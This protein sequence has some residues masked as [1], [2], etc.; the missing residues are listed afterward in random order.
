MAFARLSRRD[1]QSDDGE[2]QQRGEEHQVREHPGRP[3]VAGLH[4][5]GENAEPD[6]HDPGCDRQAEEEPSEPRRPTGANRHGHGTPRPAPRGPSPGAC[7]STRASQA[8]A[9]TRARGGDDLAA[10]GLGL[11]PLR[12]V[13][14]VADHRVLEPSAA[15]DRARHHDARCSARCRRRATP[16][17]STPHPAAFSSASP[18]LHRDRAAH[19][20]RRR[21]PRSAPARR[22]P[23]SPRRPGTCR[24]SRRARRSPRPS[25]R[26]ADRPPRRYRAR[27]AVPT[28]VEKPRMSLNSTVTSTSRCSASLAS[29][30]SPADHL[31][32]ARRTSASRP[33]RSSRRPPRA[34]ASGRRRR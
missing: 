17:P 32:R 7:R 2:R 16:T 21:D 20:L 26:G 11:Q 28:S 9:S 27:R 3:P 13:D 29:A 19:R 22:T 8:A 34:A 6:G 12:D 30:A 10:R 4:M 14:R 33:A 15:A 25:P 31:L 5:P 1:H 23:P 24:S 18:C